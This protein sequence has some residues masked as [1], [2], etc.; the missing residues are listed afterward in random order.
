MGLDLALFSAKGSP[1]TTTLAEALVACASRQGP[2][3]LA[4][5]DPDGGDR[6]A[7]PG[8][9]LDPGLASLAASVRHKAITAEDI[10]GHLQS[11]PAG[12]YV[13]VAPASAEQSHAAID[14][15]VSRLAPTLA[16]THEWSTIADCGRMRLRSPAAE[17]ASQAEVVA[18]VT[19][20]TLEGVEHARDRLARLRD[21]A[22]QFG[23]IL[24]GHSRF[25]R[26]QVEEALGVPVYGV[27]AHDERGAELVRAGQA[28]SRS[29]RR[30]ALMRSVA[31]L[32]DSLGS[33]R[34]PVRVTGD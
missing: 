18:V 15:V 34:L 5:L 12:G 25:S 19:R 11:L 13:L 23:A 29:G 7:S 8:L 28:T 17:L 20:P 9:A 31:L 27:V 6:A 2:A 33:D 3:L 26:A 32:A 22:P 16:S 30:T 1:G 10:A 4:E 14:A 24:V 21:M